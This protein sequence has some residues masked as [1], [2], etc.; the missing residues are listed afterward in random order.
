M[1][2]K[3]LIVFVLLGL[4]SLAADMVYEGAR[5]ASG[6][7]LENLKAPPIA[8]SIIGVGEF[9]GY[10]LRF[11]SGV[12]ASYLGSSAA[13]WGFVALGYAM[14]VM[15]LPFLAFVGSWQIATLLYLL[16]RVGKGLRT[17]MRDVIL[18]E[19]TEG[20]GRGKGFGLH[21]VMDQVGALVGPLFFA[22][23]LV[24]YDYSKAFLVLLIPGTL[25]MMFVL[26][27]WSLYPK[28]RGVEVSPKK[29]SFKGLGKRFWL[30]ALSMSLQ[31][32]G[33]VHWAIASYF[34][35]CWGIIGD[36]E[37]AMLYAIA[38]GVDAL[39]A[40]PVGYLY[41]VVK[42]RS[43]YI[44]PITTLMVTL[45]LATKSTALAYVMAVLWGI[46]MG[47]SETIMR[48]SIADIVD[49]GRLAIA[50]GIFGM[51]YG[52]SWGIGG[53]IITL[54]LQLSL[55]VTIGYATLAQALSL[56]ILIVLNR[57]LDPQDSHH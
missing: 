55:P 36:A 4:I 42:Y 49:R 7:Y 51:L 54:L 18:A 23:M 46:T 57:Q 28:I 17:P 12:V 43:L 31:S 35:K 3:I 21:E 16:E 39:I 14:N 11:V 32:L 33:F 47:I 8:S 20:V 56:L 37:I 40:F 25:A 27:A 45:L 2:K 52:I 24:H 10:V 15:V 44:A 22:Y 19:V 48:A 29:L 30:Y 9:V 41:D 50:Y 6:A 13:F 26:T 53:F 34:L 5:S 38:M 1:K